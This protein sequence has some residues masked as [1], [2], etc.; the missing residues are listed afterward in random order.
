MR[1]RSALAGSETEESKAVRTNAGREG[2]RARTEGTMI[3]ETYVD[4]E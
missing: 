3:R 1:S 4:A 2:E